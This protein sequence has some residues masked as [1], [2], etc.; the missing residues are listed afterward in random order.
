MS[1]AATAACVWT[2]ATDR[3]ADACVGGC[4]WRRRARSCARAF[5]HVDGDRQGQDRRHGRC[6]RA[7][8]GAFR[9]SRV[10]YADGCKRRSRRHGL[11]LGIGHP[12][13]ANLR[14]AGATWHRSLVVRGPQRRRRAVPA[15][16]GNDDG[17]R[18]PYP[19]QGEREAPS[20]RRLAAGPRR[21]PLQRSP[22]GQGEG[23]IPDLARRLAGEFQ[24]QGPRPCSDGEYPRVLPVGRDAHHRSGAHQEARRH[25][26]W[27]F[28]HGH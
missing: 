17:R 8:L 3:R 20:S 18:G 2:P 4:G 9:C 1:C 5:R 28:L 13:G 15:R 6:S 12:G 22:S 7:R 11:H 23:R 16:Y 27:T 19:Q 21:P 26:H 24:L 25:G 14:Q 10:L